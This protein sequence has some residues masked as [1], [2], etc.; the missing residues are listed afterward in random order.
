[1]PELQVTLISR[2]GDREYEHLFGKVVFKIPRDI[3]TRHLLRRKL[4]PS[5]ER[6]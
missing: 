2:T 4:M 5:S 6:M 1:M 3:Y